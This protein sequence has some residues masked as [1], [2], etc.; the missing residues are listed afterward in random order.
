MCKL[1]NVFRDNKTNE[2][3]ATA[4]NIYMSLKRCKTVN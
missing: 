2:H 4:K 1:E 3:E